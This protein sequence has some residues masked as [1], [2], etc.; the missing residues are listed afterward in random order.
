[1]LLGSFVFDV[2]TPLYF[3]HLDDLTASDSLCCIQNSDWPFVV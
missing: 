1:M 3:A 2:V